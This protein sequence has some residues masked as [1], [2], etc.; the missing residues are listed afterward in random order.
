MNSNKPIF[1]DCT[2]RDG[3]YYVDWDFDRELVDA[4]L[5][6][7]ASIN[8][9]WVELGF[10]FIENKGFKGANAY[11]SDAYLELLNIPDSLS[12]SVMLNAKDLIVDDTF[13]SKNLDILVPK[14]AIQSK[15]SLIRIACQLNE[16]KLIGPA[17]ERIKGKGY[18]VALNLMQASSLKT[19]E[20]SSAITSLALL[21]IDV[22]Y[23][24]DS[25]GSLS[26]EQTTQIAQRLSDS[27]IKSIGIHA[28]DNL[29]LALFNTLTAFENGVTWLDATVT[30][31]GRG[32]GNAKTEELMIEL[33]EETD[34]ILLTRLIQQY[35]TP[36]KKQY[37]WGTNIY[38]YLSAKR[39]VHPSYVQTMLA[40][41]RYTS[42][43]II[44]IL[45]NLRTTERKNFS[46]SGLEQAGAIIDNDDNGSWEPKIDFKNKTV[47]ILGSG[48]SIQKHRQAI[49]A[50]ISQEKPI[51]IGLNATNYV[52][53]HLISFRIA[54]HPIRLMSD[55]G[56]Y[57][58]LSQ[59]LITPY[60]ILPQDIKNQLSETAVLDYG[61]K[62]CDD[63]FKFSKKSCVIPSRLV[64][65]YALA[66][67][68]SGEA[69]N[70]MFA[71][72]DG[73]SVG[74]PRNKEIDMLLS[75]YLAHPESLSITSIT[76]TL[77]TSI[78]SLS[79]YG[80]NNERFKKKLH[81]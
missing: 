18:K 54:V 29:G 61:V 65:A 9:D 44:N 25:L 57:S 6:A 5:A 2:L 45:N 40:D 26:I 75:S 62:I 55:A 31:M 42:D 60:S 7:M 66:V 80:L 47:L 27:S 34:L 8:I 58:T 20:L 23:F 50:F 68:T 76:P 10:R 81:V 37:G 59:P 38:Y 1:L 28:H 43:D 48:P 16:L 52:D 15:V 67:T 56:N 14:P 73:Y 46:F 11:T 41:E 12:I 19:G 51:V 78:A 30:G 36:M 74:D 69:A 79:V 53:E 49:E 21:P 70:I 4:Y 24:A 3:G 77:Y 64:L 13:H 35:F 63:G 32:P 72:F 22:F 71:G 17:V 33:C 39:G